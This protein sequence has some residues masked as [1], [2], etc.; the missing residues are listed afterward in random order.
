MGLSRSLGGELFMNRDYTGIAPLGSNLEG[1]MASPLS[2]GG[3]KGYGREIMLSS[4][5]L[6]D[7]LKY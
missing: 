7:E 5:R 3:L 1:G 2:P 4:E 6:S